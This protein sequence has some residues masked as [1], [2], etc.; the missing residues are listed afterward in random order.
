MLFFALS[1][2]LITALVALPQLLQHQGILENEIPFVPLVILGSWIP[3]I[4]A[5]LVIAFVLKESGGVRR[6]LREWTR[7]RIS[8]RWYLVA[9]SALAVSLVA[10]AA[11]V[12]VEPLIQS[13]RFGADYVAGTAA[14]QSGTV[15]GGALDPVNGLT[16]PM[17]L[18]VLLLNLVTGAMGE[19]LGWRGF[20][21]P[22][23][24]T[25]WNALVSSMI[26]GLI[27]GV[28]HLPLWFAG[29]GWEQMSF[30]LFLWNCV[31]MSV[32]YTWICNNTRGNMVI[33]TLFHMLYNF[34]FF[35][36]ST[37][38]SIPMEKGIAYLAVVLTVYAAV[39][40]R[41][42]GA[43]TLKDGPGPVPMDEGKGARRNDFAAGEAS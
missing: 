33:V 20:A 4:A 27:W 23:L 29:I 28:W 11:Y 38:W 26:L 41:R 3:N 5:F 35:L 24:Q 32:I 9:L 37:L 34:G 6:L 18:G 22:R 8:L 17:I 21:L 31:A 10:A 12:L 14:S 2:V 42:F 7:W 40:I 25:R 30:W 39:L 16:L 13:A 1:L 19:E 15:G 36:V 43:R